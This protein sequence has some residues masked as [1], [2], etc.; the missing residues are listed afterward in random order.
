MMREGTWWLRSK[1]DPRW[2]CN[3]R[4][5]V[6]MFGQPQDLVNKLAELT[7]L[8]GEPPEDLEWGYMK[9]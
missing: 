8:Y 1:T 7:K 3:G 4:A 2:D 5:F 6:G 9:D